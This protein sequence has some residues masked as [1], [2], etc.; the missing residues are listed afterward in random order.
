MRI[1]LTGFMGSGKSYMGQRLAQ[2]SGLPFFD[3]DEMI[4]TGEGKS[5]KD[6]FT[7]AGEDHFRQLERK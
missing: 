6:I 1:F 4:E 7:E 2:R 5:V 3:L